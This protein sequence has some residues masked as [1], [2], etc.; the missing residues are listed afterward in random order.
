MQALMAGKDD[1]IT[2]NAYLLSAQVTAC[3]PM[4]DLNPRPYP[5]CQQ[6]DVVLNVST[7]V[8]WILVGLGGETGL[9]TPVFENAILL[10]QGIKSITTN[11]APTVTM[12]VDMRAGRLAA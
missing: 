6:P 11:L 1:E 9:Y 5:R 4:S 7:T 3:F 10:A 12:S 2:E 8:R